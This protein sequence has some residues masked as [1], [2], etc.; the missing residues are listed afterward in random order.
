MRIALTATLIILLAGI[1]CYV[2]NLS[3]DIGLDVPDGKLNSLSFA[4]FREGQNPLLQQFPTPE[5]IDEDLKLLA[6]KTHS[7]RT[8]SSTYGMK[9]IPELAGKHGLK[10][11]QGGWVGYYDYNVPNYDD[12]PTRAE[13]EM[14][15]DLANKYPDV[16]DRVMVGNEVLL[17]GERTAE[18]LIKF[19]REVKQRVKQPVSYADVWSMYMKHPELIKE[20]DF[21]TIHILPYWEDEP[22]PVEKAPAHIER[23]YKQ[24][25]EEAEAIAPGKPILI[26]ETGWPSM[27]KQRGW[28]VPGVVNEAAFIRGLLK[29]AADNRFDVNIV[30][31]FNQP[32][33]SE[34]EGVIGANWG[35]FDA[36]RKEVFPLTGPV[37]ENPDWCM[38]YLIT[39]VLM[40]LI[41]FFYARKLNALPVVKIITFLLFAQILTLLFTY[42]SHQ[43]WYASYDNWQR[44]RS[45]L[46]ML[47]SIA[48]IALILS[49]AVDIVRNETTSE[50]KTDALTWVYAVVLLVSMYKTYL[51][52][53]DGRYVSFPFAVTLIPVTGLLGL[54]CLKSWRRQFTFSNLNIH[55]LFGKISYIN[56]YDKYIG[57]LI[58]WYMAGLVIGE[59]IAFAVARDF[60]QAYPGLGERLRWAA[61][62]TL[63]N[64]Q[65]LLWLACL[66]VLALTRLAGK[67][68]S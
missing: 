66:A 1:F 24:V 51:L 13:I 16:I 50:A 22:I 20:V 29:V 64:R 30:E 44:F 5:Q 7:I 62:F 27:G 33:K 43:S 8:Y 55:S 38:Q 4:P 28:A 61:T 6:K 14:L 36:N 17:R 18:D 26:G 68:R 34:L 21:I 11:I 3:E 23:I 49:R 2:F 60:I 46:V 52:A 45:L 40:V 54:F 35:L 65:L 32:W 15:V 58:L 42:L 57:W 12:S 53:S 19:I 37:Y 67:Q 10:L 63:T 47:L 25:R 31:A 41:T 59:I 56:Q 39:A 9:V 48:V